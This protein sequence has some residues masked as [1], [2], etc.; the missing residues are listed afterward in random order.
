MI[1]GHFFGRLK[2]AVLHLYSIKNMLFSDPHKQGVFYHR[3]STP[4]NLCSLFSMLCQ[5]PKLD[6]AGSIPVSRSNLFN[7]LEA[8]A[9]IDIF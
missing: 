8:L 1:A 9:K 6:V 7:K 2:V 3:K 4:C 5:F